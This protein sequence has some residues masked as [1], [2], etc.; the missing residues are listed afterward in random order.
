MKSFP[1]SYRG[2]TMKRIALILLLA[3]IV[4]N[5]VYADMSDYS[6]TPYVNSDNVGMV[7]S[8]DKTMGLSTAW[9]LNSSR[10][11]LGDTSKWTPGMGLRLSSGNWND[12]TFVVGAGVTT[13]ANEIDIK[14]FDIDTYM[15]AVLTR[16]LNEHF[17]LTAMAVLNWVEAYQLPDMDGMD[18]VR[19]DAFSFGVTFGF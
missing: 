18:V 10:D 5:P 15:E 14:G 7:V 19:D 12:W 6:F 17:G 2:F 11:D 1:L 13:K 9:R 4:S 16:W 3:L 8:R